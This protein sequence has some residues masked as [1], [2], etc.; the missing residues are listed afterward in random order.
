VL[1]LCDERYEDDIGPVLAHPNYDK[2]MTGVHRRLDK[3]KADK[4]LDYDKIAINEGSFE[5]LVGL[6][7]C[8]H[9]MP[10][11]TILGERQISISDKRYQAKVQLLGLHKEDAEHQKITMGISKNTS[12]NELAKTKK[13]SRPMLAEKSIFDLD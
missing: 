7:Q 10:C 3:D 9:R 6:D 11:K 5:M 8:A 2:T 13:K 1:E 12:Y 4:L